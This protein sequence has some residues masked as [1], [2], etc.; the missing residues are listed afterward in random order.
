M[1]I[2]DTPQHKFG[3][4]VMRGMF[5]ASK[6]LGNTITGLVEGALEGARKEIT[7]KRNEK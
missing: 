1:R 7:N 5:K 4:F 2:K 3:G 6:L